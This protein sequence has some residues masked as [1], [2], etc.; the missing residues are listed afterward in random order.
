MQ[1]RIP[2]ISHARTLSELRDEFLSDISRL[3]S[4][5]MQPNPSAVARLR[6]AFAR[7]ELAKLADFWSAVELR[8]ETAKWTRTRDRT[9]PNQIKE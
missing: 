8:G 3:Q 1:P 7:D 6:A 2:F 4:A 5:L 9:I